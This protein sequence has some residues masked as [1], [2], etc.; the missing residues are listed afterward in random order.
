MKMD[1]QLTREKILKEAERCVC[2][3]RESVYGPP[4][5]SF[6]TISLFWNACL[7]SRKDKDCQILDA[8]DVAIM[9][10]LLKIARVTT[11]IYK[12][13]SYVDACGYMACAGEIGAGGV[14]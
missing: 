6:N 3:N 4:E 13:D 11:G 14:D 1:D 9:M 7:V 2:M 5:D 12:R 8:H 10:A